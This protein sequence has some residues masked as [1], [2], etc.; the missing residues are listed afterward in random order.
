MDRHQPT[1][2][3]GLIAIA[4][5]LFT[6]RFLGKPEWCAALADALDR[7]PR[8]VLEKLAGE[9]LRT[10]EFF[11][12]NLLTARD[13]LRDPSLLDE[14]EIGV[15][16]AGIARGASAD[17]ENLA[18]LCGTLCLWARSGFG[19]LLPLV[20]TESA[21]RHCASAAE[22]SS[23]KLIRLAAGLA[24]LRPGA[25][26]ARD[27]EVIQRGLA[28]LRFPLEVPSQTL[29]LD[30]VRLWIEEIPPR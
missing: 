11:L 4:H 19:D 22:P 18:A 7:D 17:Q 24:A 27:R 16:I 21:I 9:D 28:A 5:P 26:P 29:A 25:I 20:V 15:A 1:L 2:E 14:P 10:L 13:D 12:W 30:R 23:P 6:L 8:C 3:V